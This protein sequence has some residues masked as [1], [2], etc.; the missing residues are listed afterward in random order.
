LL[1]PHRLFLNNRDT[2]LIFGKLIHPTVDAGDARPACADLLG[3][4]GPILRSRTASHPLRAISTSS[5]GAHRLAWLRRLVFARA[6][7]KIFVPASND[8]WVHPF[9]S[10]VASFLPSPAP[11]SPVFSLSLVSVLH[12]FVATLFFLQPG[13][14]SSP[15]VLAH[16]RSFF[17]PSLFLESPFPVIALRLDADFSPRS[18]SV[19]PPTGWLLFPSCRAPVGCPF[20]P[21]SANNLSRGSFLHPFF[22]PAPP[23][24]CFQ[25]RPCGPGL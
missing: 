14:I 1:F 25:L 2:V 8:L 10:I 9:L 18:S 15:P 19:F 22:P 5:T 12:F 13:G 7:L 4:F 17:F 6:S 24:R 11:M 23:P 3:I 20:P 21:L 16:R